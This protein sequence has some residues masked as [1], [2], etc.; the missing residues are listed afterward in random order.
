[1]KRVNYYERSNTSLRGFS[2]GL[3]RIM[4]WD[5]GSE[6]DGRREGAEG[7]WFTTLAKRYT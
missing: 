1:M 6:G 5:I 3:Q 2:V 7:E 4:E